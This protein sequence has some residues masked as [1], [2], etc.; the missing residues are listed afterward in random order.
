MGSE[1]IVHEAEGN[2]NAALI[3]DRYL[4]FTKTG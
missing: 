1:S 3:I 4:D 2:Q